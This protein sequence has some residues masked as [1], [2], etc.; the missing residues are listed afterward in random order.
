MAGAIRKLRLAFDTLQY[1]KAKQIFFQVYYRLRKFVPRRHSVASGYR[2][3]SHHL[4]LRESIIASTSLKENEF[5]FLNL[6]K[7]F[8]SEIDWNYSGYGKLWTYNLNYF[9]FLQQSNIEE[10]E[11]LRLIESYC[12]QASTLK[13]GIEPYPISLRGINWIKYF[14]KRGVQNPEF[15]RV[16]FEHYLL[17]ADN[18]EYHL[19][20][21]HLL[22]NGFSLLFGAY[23]FRNETF[24][25]K[26]SRIL[27]EELNE[28]VLQD[29]AHFE[30]STMYH[31]ILLFRLLDCINLVINNDW[32]QD[33]LL[34]VLKQKGT[35]MLGWLTAMTF[36]NGDIPMVNDAA[37]G[38]G[39]N[40]DQILAYAHRVDIVVDERKLSASGYRMI[41]SD[42]WELVVD[43]GNIGPDYIPGHAHSD[44][45][46]FVLN[47][48]DQPLAVDVGTSTYEGG[49]VRMFERSTKGHNT[50]MI[51]NCE[52]SEIWASFR[53]GRRARIFALEE[54]QN[55][56]SAAH[57]G[58]KSIG[59]VHRRIWM[60]E[61]N[62]IRILD[63]VSGSN[64]NVNSIAF[65][66]F[67]PDID[68]EFNGSVVS[69]GPVKMHFDGHTNIA[70]GTYS[71]P[72]G[73]N[74]L[75][76]ASKLQISFGRELQTVIRL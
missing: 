71:F 7:K 66:H 46:S 34:S 20:G 38:I 8:D 21:N 10:K 37:F 42:R 48:N 59:L 22:E 28:Q 54:K 64:S 55:E 25:K 6:S 44:T 36:R 62:E 31:Q 33:Q 9:D 45:L 17:L 14:S 49:P 68:V 13:D 30:L 2:V 35:V 52:Q 61:G 3:V 39:P 74:A 1:L 11:A 56:I 47:V 40:T 27:M 26:A 73:F 51:N 16:L 12:V 23:Y 32:K 76:N 41:R 70:I 60:W 43:V 18:L 57:D 4:T 15:D 19:L 65:F 24:Y 29:G 50:V 58:Y 5:T 63:N 75:R 72:V 53:V 69:A 67:H